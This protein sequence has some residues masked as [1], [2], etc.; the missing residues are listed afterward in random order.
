MAVRYTVSAQRQLKAQGCS[1]SVYGAGGTTLST[2]YANEQGDTLANPFVWAGLEAVPTFYAAVGDYYVTIEGDALPTY[3][4]H[5]VGNDVGEMLLADGTA[6]AP[7][8]SFA[9][10]NDLGLYRVGANQM[11]LTGNLDVSAG[12]DVTGAITGTTT[13]SATTGVRTVS[14]NGQMAS[15]LTATAIS[16]ALTSGSTYTFTNLIPAGSI[17]LGVTIRVTT[18]VTGATS[19]T[20]GDGTDATRWGTGIA[21]AAGTTTTLADCTEVAVPI[22]AAATSVVLTAAGSD[23]TAGVVRATVHYISLTAA[24]S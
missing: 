24:T 5:E 11:G 14:A 9:T 21:V 13:V 20:I 2:I 16:T 10:D 3:Q 15:L 1:V 7:A 22:Y 4:K 19:M 17:V 12:V 18:L 23:F 6:G 8:L